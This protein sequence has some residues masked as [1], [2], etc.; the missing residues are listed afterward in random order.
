LFFPNDPYVSG[1]SP[2]QSIVSLSNFRII[3]LLA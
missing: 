3:L 1:S 2:E